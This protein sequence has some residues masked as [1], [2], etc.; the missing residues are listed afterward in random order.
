MF[1]LRQLTR[2]TEEPA[3]IIWLSLLLAAVEL[4]S[5]WLA[6][7]LFS[8]QCQERVFEISFL[9]C[10][11]TGSCR[12]WIASCFL[13]NGLRAELCVIET[14]RIYIVQSR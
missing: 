2:R 1:D 10:C 7:L 11:A 8:R 13:N 5:K 4:S 9:L 12:A 3:I 6:C 14:R